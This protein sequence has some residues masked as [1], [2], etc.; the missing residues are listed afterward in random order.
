MMVVWVIL[1][2]ASGRDLF[3]ELREGDL[4]K[5]GTADGD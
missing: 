4:E 1:G 5:P 3:G 2:L